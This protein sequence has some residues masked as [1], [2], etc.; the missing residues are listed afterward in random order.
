MD[1]ITPMQRALRA[2]RDCGVIRVK[3]GSVPFAY[4]DLQKLNAISAK[5]AG[6]GLANVRLNDY[7]HIL[8]RQLPRFPGDW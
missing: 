2:L 1:H 4:R 3:L 6:E 8:A 7:G 5:S